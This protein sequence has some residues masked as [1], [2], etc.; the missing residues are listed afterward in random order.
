VPYLSPSISYRRPNTG[1]SCEAPSGTGFVSFIP[2]L[3]GSVIPSLS[4]DH[5]ATALQGLY[6]FA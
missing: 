5:A 4:Y 3:G 6:E 2:L 1:I